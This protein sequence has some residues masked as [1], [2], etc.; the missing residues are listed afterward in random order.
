VERYD[1]AYRLVGASSWTDLSSTTANNVSISGLQSNKQYEF[2]A[3]VRCNGGT[4]SSWSTVK[5]FNTSSTGGSAP[6]NDPVCNASPITAGS[7]CSNTSGTTSGATPTFTDALCGTTN[8][9]DVWYKC[10]IPSTG[11]VTFRT[12]AGSLT[13]AVM[14]VFWGSGCT[15]LNYVACED[16]NDNGNGSYM[17]VM[18]ITGQAG[19]QLWIRVWGYNNAGGTFSICA[20]NYST[21]NFNGEPE[22]PVYHIDPTQMNPYPV[23][24]AQPDVAV[25]LTDRDQASE[26]TDLGAI[27]KVYPNPS[28]GFVTLPLML[29]EEASVEVWISDVLGSVVY[30]SNWTKMAGDHQVSL[31][32]GSLQPGIYTLRCSSGEVTEVQQLQVMR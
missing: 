6:A 29:T 8:P 26:K 17:P 28:N 31:D 18:T 19:T 22:G 24:E 27:G 16:D 10:V 11:K 20:M 15:S 2:K 4:W 13:D 3:A 9:K 1:W 21:A 5:T 23:E 14:A 12:T 7:S 32:L 30:R 25:V